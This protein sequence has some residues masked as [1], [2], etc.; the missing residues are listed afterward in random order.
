[1]ATPNDPPGGIRAPPRNRGW[2]R[3]R[4]AVVVSFFIC[5]TPFHAQRLIA[6]YA[7]QTAA[8]V[9]L[10]TV[11]TY[12]SGVT[13]YLSATVNPILYQVMSLK[14]R[15]AF[16]DTFG[17]CCPEG[18][19]LS[20]SELTFASFYNHNSAASVHSSARAH[21]RRSLSTQNLAAGS[22][23]PLPTSTAPNGSVAVGRKLSSSWTDLRNG[24]TAAAATVPADSPPQVAAA[25]L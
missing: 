8:M 17:C 6:T 25:Q 5:W 22:P 20:K 9:L 11:L 1:M 23:T 14:F 2:D 19:R 18:A 15:Q 12:I 4:V 13:Y 24:G 21:R 10:F 3:R 16:V 7:D